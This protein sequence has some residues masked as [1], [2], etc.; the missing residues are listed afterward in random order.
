MPPTLVQDGDLP[1]HQTT[2]GKSS[3]KTKSS[4]KVLLATKMSLHKS[5]DHPQI[6][7]LSH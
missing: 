4:P 3:A 5:T 6:A 2:A 7:R 1:T